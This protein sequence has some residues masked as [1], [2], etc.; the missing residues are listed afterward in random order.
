LKINVIYASV[1]VLLLFIACKKI[2]MQA[3][4]NENMA[5]IVDGT[6]MKLNSVISTKLEQGDSMIY[7]HGG[8]GSEGLDL[9]IDKAK[10]Q[11]ENTITINAILDAQGNKVQ[12]TSFYDHQ[13]I[14]REL[15]I[16]PATS[17]SI[18]ISS[19][20]NGLAIGTFNFIASNASNGTTRIITSG[21][22]EANLPK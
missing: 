13:G 15:V 3:T 6:N 22:F 5:C 14:A 21:K 2:C 4:C 11:T 10:L 7:I 19:A 8:A 1:I 12:Q 20:A 16:H 9:Y 18:A 17:G